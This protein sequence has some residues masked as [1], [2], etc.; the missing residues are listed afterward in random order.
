MGQVHARI[1]Q[2]EKGFCMRLARTEIGLSLVLLV[3]IL[4]RRC[5]DTGYEIRRSN[6]GIIQILTTFIA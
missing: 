4:D 1:H 5:Y 2:T 6:L 3:Y